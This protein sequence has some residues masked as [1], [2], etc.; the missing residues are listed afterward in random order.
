[1]LAPGEGGRVELLIG[2]DGLLGLRLP[3]PPWTVTSR[4]GADCRFI[5][6]PRRPMMAAFLTGT[7][8]NWFCFF[9][10]YLIVNFDG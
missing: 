8:H 1:M 5:I 7:K 9:H 3:V 2:G 4:R 6:S 10:V